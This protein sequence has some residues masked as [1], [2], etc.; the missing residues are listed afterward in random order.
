MNK[1]NHNFTRI[2]KIRDLDITN[3]FFEKKYKCK[4]CEIQFGITYYGNEYYFSFDGL[5]IKKKTCGE[6]IMEQIVK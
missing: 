3:T 4:S 5:L 2:E 6:Y 1:D